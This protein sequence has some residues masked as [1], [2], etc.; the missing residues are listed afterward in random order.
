MPATVRTLTD[1]LQ[2][3]GEILPEVEQGEIVLR[4]RN[5]D[6]LIVIS[7][8]HWEALSASLLALAG[9]HRTAQA[10]SGEASSQTEWFALPWMSL[11]GKDDREACLRELT[12]AA[13]AALESGR[14]QPL[15]EAIAQWRATAL[16]TWDDARRQ[17]EPGYRE[18]APS[19]LA[20]P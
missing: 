15:V 11:L 6:D 20:R 14:F 13:I 9:A 10:G 16:A 12:L 4:R 18:D 7:R 1:F 5:G 2:H 8:K 17:D 19:G 3:S